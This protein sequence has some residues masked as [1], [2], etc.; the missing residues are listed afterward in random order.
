M[1]YHQ[2]F[3]LSL[4]GITAAIAITVPGLRA[5]KPDIP[6]TSPPPVVIEQT[7]YNRYRQVIERT[8][9]MVSDSQARRLAEAFGLDI[10]NVTWEDTGRFY[11]SAVGPNISDMTIQVQQQDPSTGRYQLSLMPVIRH[12]NFEDLT[13]DI[14]LDNFYVL[15]GNEQGH[16]LQ[17]V[18]LRDVLN[19]L[20]SYLHE[21]DSWPGRTQSLLAPERD[22]H[23]LVSAQACFLPIPQ[24]GTATFNPV[25]FNYQSRPN[26]PAVLTIL[27]TREGTSVTVI[28]NQRDAFEAGQTWGQRLFFNK[29]GERASFT[30]QRLSDFQAGQDNTQDSTRQGQALTEAGGAEGLNMVLMIQVPLKQQNPMVLP[31]PMED[32]AFLSGA[33][34]MEAQRAPSDVEEA[35]IGHGAVEGP[36]TEIDGVAIER[37]PDYPIRVTVQF[38][39]ATSNGIVSEADITTIRDQMDRVYADADY[40]GSL[41]VDGPSERATEHDGPKQ[42]PPGWWEQF[43]EYQQDFFDQLS[44][45]RDRLNG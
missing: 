16:N 41:V 34:E 13:A 3:L 36:F 24:E 45:F 22:S 6:T 38:Y 35:V 2:I 31:S 19:N 37:D 1:K 33:P 20:R 25:L 5:A 40:V 21:P 43:W 17:R 14:S 10:L 7:H 4:S 27:S 42:E 23:V 26:D 28:D 30:G 8:Q 18:A 32:M 15:V 11:N 29:N 44:H 12:P 39:K 9:A